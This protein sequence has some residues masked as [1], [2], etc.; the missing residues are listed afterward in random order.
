MKLYLFVN[1]RDHGVLTLNI[2][3][4]FNENL[5]KT[6]LIT[7]TCTVLQTYYWF[8]CCF[9][10]KDIVIWMHR[11]LFNIHYFLPK[12]VL[13]YHLFIIIMFRF[14]KIG[15]IRNQN[16]SK[17]HHM[18]SPIISSVL[19]EGYPLYLIIS[20]LSSAKDIP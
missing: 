9:V 20:Y 6:H 14:E 16:K 15:I 12:S 11:N 7:V 18:S 1:E 19:S 10:Y 5:D 17:A 4:I 2:I 13:K 3:L 8:L